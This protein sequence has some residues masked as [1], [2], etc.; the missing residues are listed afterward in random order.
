MT[1]TQ[2]AAAETK[3]EPDNSNADVEVGTESGPT[4]SEIIAKQAK[5]TSENDESNAL[6]QKPMS[7]KQMSSMISTSDDPFAPREGKT[8]LWRGINMTLVSEHTS[9]HVT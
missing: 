6:G 8:L 5:E 3:V 7:K 2:E 9:S 4:V 1:I